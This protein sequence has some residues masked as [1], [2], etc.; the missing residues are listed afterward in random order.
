MSILP[1]LIKRR[2]YLLCVAALPCPG[3]AIYPSTAVVN[4]CVLLQFKL[5]LIA[6]LEPS[7]SWGRLWRSLLDVGALRRRDGNSRQHFFLY[8]P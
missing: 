1:I 2:S 6:Y 5:L 8:I 4:L 7:S 3:S